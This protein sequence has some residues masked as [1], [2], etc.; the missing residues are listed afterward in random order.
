[1]PRRCWL[2]GCGYNGTVVLL[3]VILLAADELGINDYDD[4]LMQWLQ[5]VIW[6]KWMQC[7]VVIKL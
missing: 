6:V 1:M 2:W 4:M 3:M 7:L 5:W